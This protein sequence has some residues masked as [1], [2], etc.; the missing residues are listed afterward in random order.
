[1]GQYSRCGVAIGRICSLRIPTVLWGNRDMS[2]PISHPVLDSLN[3]T[4]TGR[5]SH[6]AGFT[7]DR[8]PTIPLLH[9]QSSST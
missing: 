7:Y 2:L 3:K 5:S 1:M 9:Q 8:N 6:G 4:V